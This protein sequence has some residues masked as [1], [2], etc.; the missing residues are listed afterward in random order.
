MNSEVRW[1]SS[2]EATAE[3]RIE[4]TSEWRYF[5]YSV[6]FD[7]AEEHRLLNQQSIEDFFPPS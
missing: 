4:T 1:L 6:G 5:L 7:T 2:P 3:G